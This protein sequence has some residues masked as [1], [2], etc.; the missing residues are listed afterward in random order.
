VEE[1]VLLEVLRGG[2]TAT[3]LPSRGGQPV[4]PGYA[5][6]AGEGRI[7]AESVTASPDALPVT[8]ILRAVLPQ[9]AE[10]LRL[11]L[12]VPELQLKIVDAI[13]PDQLPNTVARELFRAVVLAREPNDEGVH[14]PFSLTALVQGLDDETA[15][16]AQAIVAKR[17]P[18]PRRLSDADLAYEVER[19]IIDLEERALDERSDYIQ[20]ALAEA[21]Q[22]GEAEAIDRLIH[23]GQ[24]INEQRL[25]LHRRSAQTTLLARPGD[26]VGPGLG[27]RTQPTEPV[28]ASN[29]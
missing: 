12:L 20:S 9:E 23:E 27:P 1:R 16:L 6:A 3:G 22:A 5:S 13:G 28:S 10:L 19:L 14:P 26:R 7:T 17:E 15:A 21:E 2:R 11:L 18:D 25:S 29:P 4:G 8:E 24:A